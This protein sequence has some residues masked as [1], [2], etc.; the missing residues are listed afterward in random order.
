MKRFLT[1]IL[2]LALAALL[3]ACGDEPN[4]SESAGGEVSSSVS[5]S[6][7]ETPTP[8][9]PDNT[10][11]EEAQMQLNI[12]VNGHLLTAELVDNSST[13]ALS[14]LLADGP[15]TIEMRDY[16]GMEKVGSLPQALP[17]NDEQIDTDAGDLILYQGN[18]FVIYY[19]TNSW[20][21]T[22]LGK[23]S[24]ASKSELREILGSG[25]VIAVLSIPKG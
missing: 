20:S 16:A 25:N 17:R 12:E 5:S 18:S 21:L 10:S 6:A 23:I 4:S 1:V 15:V 13:R 11:K 8:S 24:N 22:R 9:E 7:V 19:D 14:E 3:T 2:T